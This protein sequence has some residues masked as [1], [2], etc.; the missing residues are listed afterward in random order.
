M[1]QLSRTEFLSKYN[2]LFADNTS[3]AITEAILREF[4]ADIKDSY[5]STKE[6]V[7][8]LED[9]NP[10]KNYLSGDTCIYGGKLKRAQMNTTGAFDSDAWRD[11][12]E[13][14][15]EIQVKDLQD[16]LAAN[17]LV[18][19]VYKITDSNH[20]D[21]GLYVKA[22]GSN[23]VSRLALGVFWLAD[24][25]GIGAKKDDIV[26]GWR[27]TT[28]TVPYGD[29]SGSGF[30]VGE[31]VNNIT[32][33]ISGY[34]VEVSD[35]YI[36]L[37][38][39]SNCNNGWEL[40]DELEGED[41][42]TTAY[43]TD[44][45]A[46]TFP[47]VEDSIVIFNNRHYIN[48]TGFNTNDGPDIDDTNW[49]VL[50][51]SAENG[52]V[53]EMDR[54]EYYVENNTKGLRYDKRSNV[55]P[56]NSLFQWGNNLVY[57]NFFPM[58]SNPNIINNNGSI[59][60][61]HSLGIVTLAIDHRNEA[62]IIGNSFNTR[63]SLTLNAIAGKQIS[64]N[65]FSCVDGNFEHKINESLVGQHIKDIPKYEFAADESVISIGDSS[66]FL[67]I[68][69]DADLSLLTIAF[70][71]VNNYNGKRYTITSLKTIDEL[72]IE[73]TE[74][75]LGAPSG[76]IGTVDNPDSFTLQYIQDINSWVRIK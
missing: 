64:G 19:G 51:K 55:A 22:E 15:T 43:A 13:P 42:E 48:I 67:L 14:I 56:A 76:M 32:K 68:D 53:I 34:V 49:E 12:T 39:L 9:Y 29:M 59:H 18:V 5:Y 52:Y 10:D 71:V 40:N 46:I 72:I 47:V 69:S 28:I 4:V 75:V 11:V 41:S 73:A 33:S 35:E 65:I 2:T 66:E 6:D 31:K 58:F 74:P 24:Y 16:L 44:D 60:K 62:S 21:L 23:V 57:S 26:G 54:V 7:T 36:K 20:A 1:S 45:T 63:T 61:N 38:N 30:I 27:E 17:S 25:N 8:K 3:G 70:G 37:N 50:S